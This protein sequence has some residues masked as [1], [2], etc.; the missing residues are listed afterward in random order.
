M[1]STDKHSN[2]DI[3]KEI[4]S[5]HD[6]SKKI[7]DLISDSQDEIRKSFK[8]QFGFDVPSA[9]EALLVAEDS[10]LQYASKSI[11]GEYTQ[12]LQNV[13]ESLQNG[14]A[15]AAL[16][17]IQ[18]AGN[19]LD[20]VIGSDAIGSTENFESRQSTD[21]GQTIIS[22]V[23]VQTSTISKKDWKIQQDFYLSSYL[24]I[25]FPSQD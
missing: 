10:T 23:M 13:V 3:L 11:L 1:S 19:V 17:T 6:L 15:N 16:A 12:G 14:Y 8:K 9:A 7:D 18:L 22:A 21:N 5:D 4:K 20:N 2:K 25:V 24:L